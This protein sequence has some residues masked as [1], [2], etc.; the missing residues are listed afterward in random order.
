MDKQRQTRVDCLYSIIAF[1]PNKSNNILNDN[2]YPTF[3]LKEW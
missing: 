3:C 1:H 2:I